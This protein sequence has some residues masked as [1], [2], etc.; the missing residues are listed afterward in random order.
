[1]GRVASLLPTVS[2]SRWVHILILT[3]PFVIV[4]IGWH[5]LT[6]YVMA[7]QASDEPIHYGIVRVVAHQWPHPLLRGY[8]AWSGPLIYWL[9][10][11]LARPFGGSLVAVRLVVCAFSWGT[12]AV[13]Y[14][15]FRDRLD[16]RPLDALG[17][18]LLL[19][20]S[21]FFFGQSFHV[22]TDNPTWFFVVLG[23]ERLLAFVQLPRLTR[24]A[25]F[26]VCLVAA[27]LMR[28]VAV[29]LLAPGLVALASVPLPRRSRIAG[30]VLLALA[31]VPLAALLVYWGGL[32]PPAPG[33]PAA[34]TPLALARRTRNL[35]L[36]LG[37]VGFY[38]VLML[39]A[40]EIATW[41]RR[42]R[43]ER[44]W[45]IVLALPAAV[46]A[47]LLVL[48]VLGTITSFLGGLV[49]RVSFPSL[50]GSSL[51]WWI[52]IPLGSAVAA[53]LLATR[54]SD[55]R[56]RVLVSALLG[57]LLSSMVNFRWYE[58]YVDFPV[59]L[60]FAGLAVVGG[61]T[62]GRIDRERWLLAGLISVGSFLWFL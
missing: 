16:A 37:V 8:G 9:L 15:M 27:T 44:A 52:L 38:A 45:P 42:L 13:A 12:C 31:L 46:A 50:A 48:G 6:H 5:G 43:H 7:F 54:L 24:L 33:S 58:R 40:A 47:G 14:V 56:S 61:V 22:L 29:W 23:L 26:A 30:L 55:V 11:T 3:L 39:P 60:V 2:D 49:S 36:T 32:L 51:L 4:I 28:Q 1:V 35:L 59:L 20:V 34:A 57:L 18:A 62:M 10:A 41:W 21:P 19:A 25:G 17:L 53:G